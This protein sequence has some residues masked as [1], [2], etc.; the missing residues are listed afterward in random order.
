M[1]GQQC[2]INQIWKEQLR[3]SDDVERELELYENKKVSMVAK[4]NER[5]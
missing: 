3:A 1:A 5:C 2:E 4:V